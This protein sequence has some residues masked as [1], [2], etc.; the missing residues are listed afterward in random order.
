[1]DGP[2]VYRRRR[3]VSEWSSKSLHA[4]A[5]RMN[6]DRQSADLTEHQEWLWDAIVSELEYRRRH[7]KPV[8]RSC[9]CWLCVP[10]FEP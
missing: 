7:T 9:S 2:R 8:W 3:Y 6:R 10:P 1:M 5:T 4:V